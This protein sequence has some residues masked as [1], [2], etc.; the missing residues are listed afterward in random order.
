MQDFQARG[1]SSVGASSASVDLLFV[2]DAVFYPLAG[3][4]LREGDAL[5]VR[6]TNTGDVPKYLAVF[7]LDAQ[8]ELHWIYPAYVD[9][10]QNPS[11][12]ALV[13][14]A[15]GKLLSEVVEPEAPAQG[16]LQV[17]ALVTAAPIHV[18]EIESLPRTRLTAEGIAAAFSGANLQTWRAT[19]IRE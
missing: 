12:V 5:A 19:W 3:A 7:A 15:R 10:A 2:R 16:K 11:S 13:P 14:P 9:A 1:S 8:R 4:A 18:R 17:F 6:Y